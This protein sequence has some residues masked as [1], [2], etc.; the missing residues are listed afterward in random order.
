MAT[1]YRIM[2]PGMASAACTSG[3]CHSL[4]LI[5]MVPEAILGTDCRPPADL[6]IKIWNTKE[7]G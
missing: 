4:S 5:F 3:D 6:P 1:S 2:S 7:R